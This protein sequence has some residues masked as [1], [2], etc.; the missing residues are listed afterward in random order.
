MMQFGKLNETRKFVFVLACFLLAGVLSSCAKSHLAV[1]PEA[2]VIPDHIFSSPATKRADGALWPG[3]TAGNLLFVD[4]KA[5][6]VGDILTVVISENATST[7]SATTDTSKDAE[8]SMSWESFLGLPSNLGVQNFLGS[9][10]QFDPRVAAALSRSN[11]GTGETSRNGNLT[12]TVTVVITHV[13]PN[14]NFAIEGTRS[15][16][17]N[18]EEQIMVLRGIIRPVDVDFDNTI[19][20][21]L[22]ANASISYSGEGVVADEQRVGWASRALSY[23]WPF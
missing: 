21:R 1:N 3:D 18:H 15:V 14:G 23:I 17:V 10:A 22:I 5:K 4:T 7:Q 20:S 6:E 2:A 13:Y 11:K 16:T 12:A 9:G 19:S 8:T